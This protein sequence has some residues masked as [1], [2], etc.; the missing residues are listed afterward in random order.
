MPKI[1]AYILCQIYVL[2][3]L[4]AAATSS[5][6]PYWLLALGLLLLMLFTW[7]GAQPPR[8]KVLLNI[9]TL[10]LMPP[11]LVATLER[12]TTLSPAAVQ[13]IAVLLSLPL[14][15]LLDNYLKERVHQTPEFIKAR[16]ERHTTP[17]F[18]SLLSTA[19]AIMVIAPLVNHPVLLFTGIAFTL[20]LLG[21][22]TAILITIPRRPFNTD[23][24]RK[25]IIAGAGE[26]VPLYVNSRAALNVHV[27]ISPAEPW[28]QVTPPRTTM[29][30][31]KTNLDVTFT[32]PLA[33]ESR[34]VLQVT[35]TD[36]WGL[37]Q[38]NQPLQ[39]LQI[40]VIPRAKYAAWLARKYLEQTGSGIIAA[41]TLP[42]QA[43]RVALRGTEYTESRT[44]QPGDPL[45]DI[46]WKHTMKLSQLIVSEYR[47]ASEQAAIIA[48][49]LAV[50]DTE[51]ADKLAFNLVTA[52]LTLAREH[53]PT[54]LTAYNHERVILN[55]AITEPV[56][57]LRQVLS[58][59]G[60]IRVVQLAGRHLE[61]ADIA[62][63]R[64]N[65]NQLK[66]A[67]T[68]PARRLLDILDFE[69]RSIEEVARTHPI[70]LALA[71]ATSQVPAPA[72]ILLVSQLNHDAEAA[73]VTAEKLARRR[74]T[75]V[76]VEAV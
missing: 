32:P 47:E 44:Y 72:M 67:E 70:M 8:F 40:Q 26:T 51:A 24:V 52:A 73:L 35:A 12:L 55:T 33:G 19:I 31:S 34:P 64:R 9:A 38:I 75:T 41:A 18:V 15:Y 39:P 63:I 16:G 5:S 21:L 59:V 2:L 10:F 68:E 76:P 61:P 62:R 57:T 66:K 25:R 28:V 43:A 11:A 6:F 23:T 4:V 1:S 29:N 60:E 71:N 13:V 17:V 54:A 30:R 48:V 46:D 53:I 74:F 50:D 27:C 49:N 69:R 3:L 58:L 22:L 42:P 37:T 56:N 45:K 20:Y 36:P 14:I 7:L 65:I